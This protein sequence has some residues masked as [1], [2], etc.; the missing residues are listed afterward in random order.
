MI[1]QQRGENSCHGL[2]DAESGDGVGDVGRRDD[3]AFYSIAGRRQA[4][5]CNH[6]GERNNG[7]VL[8]VAE[9][10]RASFPVPLARPRRFAA[11]NQLYPKILAQAREWGRL[12]EMKRRDFLGALAAGAACRL[13][14]APRPRIE[15]STI[16]SQIEALSV[17]GRPAGGT[18][19]NG[20]S[21]IGYSDSDI[22]GRK[23][24]MDLMKSAGADVR[25]DAAGNIFASRRGT[26]SSLPPLLFG[27]HI[28]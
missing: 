26:D 20:V 1:T 12:T 18:F 17:F 13:Y 25:I 21:R 3:V 10:P 8:R 2:G 27:S 9:S 15:A 19:Q 7:V 4:H 16:Q 23:F 24:V 5:D 11:N 28:D 14:A 6:K 22:A